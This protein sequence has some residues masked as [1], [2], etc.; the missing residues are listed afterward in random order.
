TAMLTIPV[1]FAIFAALRLC[2][3]SMPLSIA[4]FKRDCRVCRCHIRGKS[5]NDRGKNGKGGNGI[6]NRFATL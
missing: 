2:V 1:N 6:G 4:E 5:G 3:G